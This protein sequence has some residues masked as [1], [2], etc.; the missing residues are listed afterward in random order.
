MLFDKFSIIIDLFVFRTLAYVQ[1]GLPIHLVCDAWYF[2]KCLSIWKGAGM[3][4]FKTESSRIDIIDKRGEMHSPPV[5]VYTL[6][7][8]QEVL[9]HLFLEMVNLIQREENLRDSHDL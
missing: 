5:S 6:T 7:Y 4:G 2:Y 3:I 1:K 8:A 9:R